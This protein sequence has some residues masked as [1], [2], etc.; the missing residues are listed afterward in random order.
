LLDSEYILEVEDG[1]LPVGVLGM[2][3][4]GEADGLVAGGEVDI[5]PRDQGVDE[6]IAG[7]RE[8]EGNIESQIICGALVKIEREDGS[9]FGDSG[10]DLDGINEGLGQGSGLEGG[11]VEAVNIVPD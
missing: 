9:G 5:K 3:A 7:N 4:G 10:L 1:L 2:W 6:V 8:L 11:V